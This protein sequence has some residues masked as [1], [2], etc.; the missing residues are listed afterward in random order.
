MLIY[1]LGLVPNSDSIG[2]DFKLSNFEDIKPNSE[3]K[4]FKLVSSWLFLSANKLAEIY[5]NKI[6]Q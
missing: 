4:S 1:S 5:R 6:I 3:R 2:S